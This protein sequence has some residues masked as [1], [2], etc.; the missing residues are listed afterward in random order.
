MKLQRVWF[1][2]ARKGKNWLVMHIVFAV[3][4]IF[5]LL[6]FTSYFPFLSSFTFNSLFR[7]PRLLCFF[8]YGYCSY[9]YSKSSLCVFPLSPLFLTSHSC[10]LSTFITSRV[11]PLPFGLMWMGS[12]PSLFDCWQGL[13][14]SS[15]TYTPRQVLSYFG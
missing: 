13:S 2:N 12:I 8:P 14:L 5:F 7:L 10:L 3:I 1:C 11:Y 15:S 4:T 6:N 9:L